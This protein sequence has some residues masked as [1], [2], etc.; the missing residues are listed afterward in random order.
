MPNFPLILGL[1]WL[2]THNPVLDWARHE[3]R[4]QEPCPH[5]DPPSTLVAAAFNSP[6]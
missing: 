2:M 4:F 3:L 1:S 5:W 6:S